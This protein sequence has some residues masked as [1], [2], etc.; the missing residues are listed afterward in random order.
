MVYQKAVD[1]GEDFTAFIIVI[2]HKQF[3]GKGG[4]ADSWF[5]CY[6]GNGGHLYP[7]LPKLNLDRVLNVTTKAS[8]PNMMFRTTP[9]P[10]M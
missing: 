3:D 4:F 6:Q 10:A 8:I 7:F 1:V 9:P 5:S 2:K